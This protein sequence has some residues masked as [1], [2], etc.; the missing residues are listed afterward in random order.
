MANSARPSS[1]VQGLRRLPKN[2]WRPFFDLMSKALLGQR[3]EI[4]VASLDLGDQIVAEWVP[5]IGI[6]YDSKDDLLDVALDR[7][8]RLIR[9]PQEIDVEESAEGLKS[10]AVLDADGTKHVVRMKAPMML[11]PASAAD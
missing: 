9:R 4:E 7:A 11:P 1:V 2:E 6:T 10:V 8:G 5:L 3:A